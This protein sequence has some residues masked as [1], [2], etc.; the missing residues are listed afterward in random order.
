M[1]LVMTATKDRP[2]GKLIAKLRRNE[3]SAEDLKNAAQAIHLALSYI[4][5]SEVFKN[6]PHCQDSEHMNEALDLIA[7]GKLL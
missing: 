1:G 7:E 6:C 5:S 4:D 2:I 3:C